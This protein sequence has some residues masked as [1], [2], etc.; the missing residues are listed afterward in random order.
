MRFSKLKVNLSRIFAELPTGV[1]VAAYIVTN[2]S[3]LHTVLP[4]LAS[5]AGSDHRQRPLSVLITQAMVCGLK[6]NSIC[7]SHVEIRFYC[8][9]G[10]GGDAVEHS[11]GN[12]CPELFRDIEENLLNADAGPKSGQHHHERMKLDILCLQPCATETPLRLFEAA[13]EHSA[14]LRLVSRGTGPMIECSLRASATSSDSFVCHS[15]ELLFETQHSMGHSPTESDVRKQATTFTGRKRLADDVPS[16]DS[17][18]TLFDINRSIAA[19]STTRVRSIDRTYV[20]M[21]WE[22]IGMTFRTERLPPSAVTLTPEALRRQGACIVSPSTDSQPPEKAK[23]IS[24]RDDG[25]ETR[26]MGECA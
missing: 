22:A 19:I 20:S 1:R 7:K 16:S 15:S 23:E 14:N 6:L 26:T 2:R 9:T 24:Q 3:R 13:A 8:S 18:C 11:F 21:G 12:M 10:C 25:N 4:S 17:K 5:H